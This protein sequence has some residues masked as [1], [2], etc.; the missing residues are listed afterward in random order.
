MLKRIAAIFLS[1]FLIVSFAKPVFAQEKNGKTQETAKCMHCGK[2]VPK[3]DLV[4]R[5]RYAPSY[6]DMIPAKYLDENGDPIYPLLLC[7]KCDKLPKCMLCQ[8]PVEGNKKVKPGEM[9]LCPSCQ[10]DTVPFTDK[11]EKKKV[12]KEV[13]QILSST[14]KMD[15]RSKINVEL[16]SYD[17]MVQRHEESGMGFYC[18]YKNGEHL[19]IMDSNLGRC[20]TR[21]VLAHELGHAWCQENDLASVT[22]SPKYKGSDMQALYEGFAEFVSWSLLKE[23][24]S[25]PEKYGSDQPKS[26]LARDVEA[27]AIEEKPDRI[28]GDGFRKV[29][30]VIGD[31]KTA[32]DWKKIMKK[33]FEKGVCAYCGKLADT[34]SAGG[35]CLCRECARDTIR[36]STEAD[37]VLKDVRRVLSAEF[38]MATTHPV[39]CEIG[40]RKSIGLT[41]VDSYY[42]LGR[43]IEPDRN[44]P[45]SQ[46]RISILTGLPRSAFRTACAQQLAH[47]WM[48]ENLPH[49]MKRPIV[50]EGFADYVAWRLARAEDSECMVNYIENRWDD[51]YGGGFRKMRDLLKN[52]KNASEWKKIL[53]KEYP[54]QDA[55]SSGKAPASSK[56][57]KQTKE[58]GR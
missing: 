37:G 3:A 24:E 51:V 6:M 35:D 58:S 17:K 49:L 29:R 9:L 32:S 13:C 41:S 57:A 38:M 25:N 50:R 18:G 40:T 20:Y 21:S 45:Q 56:S 19:I 1:L 28:Y 10:H 7:P 44:K 4:V 46:Y 42:E 2:V 8:I 31:A 48:D 36:I 12:T 5:C 11:A 43:F 39:V 55:G 30:A 54:A 14:Y 33:A 52:T 27:K 22:L 26:P 47:D 53:L 23:L 15:F 16:E 34:K